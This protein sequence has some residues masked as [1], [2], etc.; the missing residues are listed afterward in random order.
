MQEVIQAYLTAFAGRNLRVANSTL[1]GVQQAILSQPDAI[2]LEVAVGEIDGVRFLKQLRKQPPTQ[3]IPVVILIYVPK[4]G[5]LQQSW[6]QQYNLPA[7]IVNPLA[8]AM[9][10]VKI[11]KVLG[12]D[13][14]S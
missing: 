6:F 9:L 5:Y 11:A 14:D 1:E 13:L 2:I 12:W 4:W 10:C 3:R 8:P 7:V